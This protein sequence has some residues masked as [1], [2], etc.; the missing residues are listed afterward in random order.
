MLYTITTILVFLN[1]INISLRRKVKFISLSLVILLGVLMGANSSNPDY[2]VYK[3]YFDMVRSINDIGF[4][5]MIRFFNLINVDYEYFRLMIT[6]LGLTSI[7][8]TV[9][10]FTTNYSFFYLLYFVFPFFIDV[11][12]IRNFFA[13]SIVLYAT[14][15][16]IEGT[17]SGT[18]KYIALV[19]IAS[20]IHLTSIVYLIFAFMKNIKK[21]NILRLLFYLVVFTIM[22]VTLYRPLFINLM[23][24]VFVLIGRFDERIF[25]YDVVSTRYGFLFYWTVQF[26][27]IWI[28]KILRSR[29]KN[30]NSSGEMNSNHYK[31]NIA[32][33]DLVYWINIISLVFIPTYA[34]HSLFFRFYR[35]LIP[36]NYLVIIPAVKQ[37]KPMSVKKIVIVLGI[38]LLSILL[39][40]VDIYRP[41]YSVVIQKVFQNNWLIGW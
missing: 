2:Y 26:C 4:M 15:Y 40:Y 1:L 39:F 21:Q 27:Y 28:I 6:I 18:K 37:L 25:Y 36:L 34:V 22:A 9:K 3:D 29:M 19:L 12:Q 13:Y 32:F 16:L 41:F 38:V 35:N 10:K 23:D 14:P 24:H 33:I 31:K 17:K 7:H 11:V 30:I 20:S 8:K 5:L